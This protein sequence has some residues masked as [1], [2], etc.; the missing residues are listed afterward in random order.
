LPTV[1]DAALVLGY[2]DPDY[3]LGGRIKLDVAAGRAAV[4]RV[5]KRLNLA[6][7]LTADAIMRLAN[8]SMIKAIQ[9]ITI[10]VGINPAEA[11][12]VGG[13][14]AAGLGIVDI[15]RE[16]G[17]R[18]ILV[19]RLASA[20]SA[21]GM[22][23]ADLMFSTSRTHFATSES[24][25]VAAIRRLQAEMEKELKQRVRRYVSGSDS[26]IVLTYHVEARYAMQIWELPVEIDLN[27]PDADL[28]KSLIAAFH[29]EHERV[30]SLRDEGSQ[31]EF[32]L[33][34]VDL[35]HA[36]SKPDELHTG[37]T[38]KG[39]KAAAKDA[40]RPAYF[41]DTGLKA[42]PIVHGDDLAPGDE[43]PGPAIVLEPTTTLVLPPR[44]QARVSPKGF[45]AISYT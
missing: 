12:L 3:F 20:F 43:I 7:D 9:Q 22:Q 27:V 23:A 16:L 40:S 11:V 17:C 6:I 29:A 39:R 8:E 18:E 4:E 2:I 34:R 45:Y 1:T 13:G 28:V 24:F 21:A 38:G 10:N 25:D 41:Q 42:V 44:T 32:L 30:F 14:G 35:R 15:G 5:A 37:F 33:W 36:V 26:S 31:V 19:P